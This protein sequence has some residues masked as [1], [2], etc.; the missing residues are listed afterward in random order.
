MKSITIYASKQYNFI[1]KKK[2]ENKNIE[3]AQAIISSVGEQKYSLLEAFTEKPT[4]VP[5]LLEQCTT[6]TLYQLSQINKSYALFTIPF[7]ISK[8]KEYGHEGNDYEEAIEFLHTRELLQSLLEEKVISKILPTRYDIRFILNQDKR[9]TNLKIENESIKE[10]YDKAL[11]NCSFFGNT[12]LAQIL[13]K[14]GADP[15]FTNE[16]WNH[17]PLHEACRRNKYKMVQLLLQNG[18]NMHLI[19]CQNKT[20]IEIARNFNYQNIIRLLSKYEE[21]EH[22]R[23]S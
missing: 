21:M 1:F 22:E 13:I 5:D 4:F 12:R 20:P 14:K 15:N 6:T 19:N 16:I 17:T 10:F 2:N 8:A 9:I 7:V 18:A 23:Y 3:T 11:Y